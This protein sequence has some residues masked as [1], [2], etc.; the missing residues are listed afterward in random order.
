MTPAARHAAAIEVI[1]AI[2]AG[3]RAEA[4]LKE[5]GRSHR[6]AGSKDRRAIRDIVFD[7]LRCWWST[8]AAGGGEDG[9]ARVLGLLRLT[10]VPVER[11]F[12]GE[13]HA[14]LPLTDAEQAV[15]ESPSTGPAAFD[16]PESVL[17]MLEARFGADLPALADV[18]R[19]RA[20]VDLRVNL[21]RATPE[22]A[23]AALAEDGIEV[24][25][26]PLSATA[27]RV[28]AGTRGIERSRAYADGLVELQDAASQAVADFAEAQPGEVVL[29]YC[30]GGGGKALA[31][32]ART[33]A[34]VIAHDIAPRRM[35]DLPERARRAGAQVRLAEPGTLGDL[36]V[37][38]VFADAPCSGSGSW[39]R[40]PEGKIRFDAGRLA[41]LNAAQDDVLRNAARHVA[42]DG[43]LVYATCSI[44]PDENEG[45]VNAFLSEVAGWHC[46]R[47]LSLSPLDGADGFFAAW[48]EKR[49]S[50]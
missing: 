28:T 30:A 14:P 38:L 6:F 27:L 1:D 24:E 23:R 22:S 35:K 9:R 15:P 26:G 18:M 16:L 20:P 45:R 7:V 5:W 42:P 48:L 32:A 29:D 31:L 19:H 10:D 11:V 37:P 43:R 34:Q 44:L 2:R 39:R 46:S 13:G 41:E 40:D 49:D 47:S 8:A 17:S 33:N 3:A 36:Q 50:A 12:S 25:P 4:A 21:L